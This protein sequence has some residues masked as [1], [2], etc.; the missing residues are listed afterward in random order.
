MRTLGTAVVAAFAAIGALVTGHAL[1]QRLGGKR[2]PPPPP[3]HPSREPVVDI[4]DAVE[5]SCSSRS[6]G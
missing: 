5:V 6:K 4:E 1:G 2:A 3:R